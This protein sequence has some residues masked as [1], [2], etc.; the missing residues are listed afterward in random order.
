[1]QRLSLSY[2]VGLNLPLVIYLLHAQIGGRSKKVSDVKAGIDLL[3]WRRGLTTLS[4]N[5]V[6]HSIILASQ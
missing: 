3:L 4:H 1:M 5:K 2:C 6:T